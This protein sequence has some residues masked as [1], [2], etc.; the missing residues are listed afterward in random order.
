MDP[1][2][3]ALGEV[4]G[5]LPQLRGVH[6]GDIEEPGAEVLHV[7]TQE[8]AGAVQLD[9]V[10]EDHH[11]PGAVVPVHGPGG[12]GENEGFHAQQSQDPDGDDQLLEGIA[13]V[14]VEAAGHADHGP[15]GDRA[16]D[17]LPGVGGHGGEQEIGDVPVI[18][19]HR[20][21][22]LPGEGPQAGAQDDADLR[23]PAGF[24]SQEVRAFLKIRAG[25]GHGL[26]PGVRRGSSRPR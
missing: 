5:Q 22:N 13:L 7:G 9:V 8:G 11:V 6:P 23:G 14:G 26:P 25:V 15:A 21:L 12:V 10:P 19:L 24:G 18:H 1:E 17:Q 3:G 16:E 4:Q 2:G 20:V